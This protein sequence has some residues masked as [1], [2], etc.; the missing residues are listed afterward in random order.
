MNQIKNRMENNQF[1]LQRAKEKEQIAE[2]QPE[3]KYGINV[4]YIKLQE[5]DVRK[6]ENCVVEKREHR[7][8]GTAKR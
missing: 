7:M 5:E 3:G 2:R 6:M 1:S 4:V 8:D